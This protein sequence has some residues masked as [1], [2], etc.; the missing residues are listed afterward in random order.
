MRIRAV[1]TR[2]TLSD[3]LTSDPEHTEAKKT[4]PIEKKL[5]R[6]RGEVKK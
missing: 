6:K 4:F 2:A 3:H 1:R 5:K